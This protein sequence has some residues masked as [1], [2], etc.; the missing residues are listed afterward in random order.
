LEKTHD[1][2]KKENQVLKAVLGAFGTFAALGA[3]VYIFGG[4]V[5]LLRLSTRGLRGEV[6]VASLPRAFL[7]SVGLAVLLQFVFYVLFLLV[8]FIQEAGGLTSLERDEG[9]GRLATGIR[10]ALVGIAT[11]VLD[12]DKDGVACEKH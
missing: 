5:L 7:V 3:A 12:A 11:A 1:E 6:V 2:G 9:D 8:A 4:I 10:L